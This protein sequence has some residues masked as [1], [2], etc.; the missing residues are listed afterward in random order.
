MS[1]KRFLGYLLIT[2]IFLSLVISK[3]YEGKNPT[4]FYSFD[5]LPTLYVAGMLIGTASAA[6]LW[7]W[8]IGNAFTNNNL[9]RRGWWLISLLFFN[10]VASIIYFLLIYRNSP[11]KPE[12]MG[13]DSIDP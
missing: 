8:M 6:I 4:T 13:A 1:L 9:K 10:W 11:H 7:L 2:L 3:Y 5:E 12:S